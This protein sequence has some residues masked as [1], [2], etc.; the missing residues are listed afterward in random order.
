MQTIS[1]VAAAAA[2]TFWT[3]NDPFVGKWR[4]DVSRSTIV[5][6]MR[7]EAVGP[8]RYRFSF[9]GAPAETIVADGTD[10]PGL[11]GTTLSVKIEDA[12]TLTVVRK[13]AGRVIVSAA[14]KLSKDG[15]TLHDAF[16]SLQPDGSKVTVDYLYRRT[17]GAF[18]FA[19]AWE[20]TAKPVG[21]KAELGIEPYDNKGLSFLTPGSDK[22]FI[23]DGRDHAVSGKDGM[24]LSGLRRGVRAMEY[25]E[26]NR[27]KVERTRKFEL[28]PDGRILTETLRTAG[29]AT[30]EVLVFERE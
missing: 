14:W 25:A 30:P 7:V 28:S 29:R 13:Q 20:S 1:F 4:L 3:A 6:E 23:F 11:P 2:S 17:S 15:R 18:G 19:G 10:Q 8:N 21:L 26:K 16:A 9:E 27:G 12:R 22:S 24:T 5:D